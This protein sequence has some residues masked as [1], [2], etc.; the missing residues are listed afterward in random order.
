[1]IQEKYKT[2]IVEGPIGV[3][4]TTLTRRLH[5]EYGGELVLE[6][7]EAN[8]FLKSFYQDSTRHALATQLFFL[9]QRAEQLRQLTQHDLF[10]LNVFSDYLFEKDALFARLTLGDEEY[11]LYQQIYSM[12]SAQAPVPDLV[13]Y[14]QASPRHLIERVNKR[15]HSFETGMTEAYLGD[16]CEAYARFFYQYNAAPLLI[17][18]SEHLN[19]ADNEDDFALLIERIT[20]M[21][22]R[23]EYFN[24]T[25]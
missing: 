10:K 19:P 4:K 7:P 24:R 15:N 8:P 16:L 5:Q 3:G 9:F 11:R 20:Q 13:I 21:R 25:E 17:I 12:L 22:G 14:L 6:A 18:N 2:I 23:R 1:M